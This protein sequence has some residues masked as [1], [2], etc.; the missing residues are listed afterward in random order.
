M[1][2]RAWPVVPSDGRGAEVA[3]KQGMDCGLE[4]PRA[5]YQKTTC[6]YFH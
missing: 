5:G 1:V 2:L 4:R 6:D 3:V